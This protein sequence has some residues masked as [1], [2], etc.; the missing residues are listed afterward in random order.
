ME[1]MRLINLIARA[2]TA[3]RYM[4]KLNY[5]LRLAWAKATR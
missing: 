2:I 4:R 5:S 3:L 1:A